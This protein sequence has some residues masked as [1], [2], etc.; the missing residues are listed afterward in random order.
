[1]RQLFLKFPTTARFLLAL[2]L[3]ISALVLAGLFH[4]FLPIPF[5]DVALL[6]IAT[7]I[8]YRMDGKSLKALG[9]NITIH[10]F[11]FL[12]LGLVIG[13]FALGLE[14]LLRTIYTGEHWNIN[15]SVNQLA[16]WKTLYFILPSVVVQELMF[17]GYLFTKTIE[18]TNVVIANVIFSILFMLIHILDKDVLQNTGQLIFLAVSIPFGHL[19]FA[20]ALLKSKTL[21]FPIGLHWG[22]N[23][24]S[25]CLI[26]YGKNE[27]VVF[28]ITNQQVFTSWVPFMIMLVIF[29]VFFLLVTLVIWKWN[30]TPLMRTVRQTSPPKINAEE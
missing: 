28:P 25:F 13:V 29:N 11:F 22:N 23:W 10:H 5:I 16:L 19:L 2:L 4:K 30:T 21:Y 3:G 17:R 20:V 12:I 26:G 15:R 18:V 14:T 7:W 27:N 1:M 8:M 24:A 6:T 9:L